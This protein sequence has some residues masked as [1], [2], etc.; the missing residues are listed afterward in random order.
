MASL[1]ELAKKNSDL[2][3]DSI[4]YLQDLTRSWGLLADLSFSDLLL[5]LP[6]KE[7]PVDSFVLLAHVR[8]TTS[9]TLYRADLVGQKFEAQSRPVVSETFLT[10]QI[11]NGKVPVGGDREISVMAIPVIWKGETVAILASEKGFV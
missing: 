8:P 5:Y 9:A 6:T 3:D 1:E 7:S 11:S 10:A 2:E 4:S